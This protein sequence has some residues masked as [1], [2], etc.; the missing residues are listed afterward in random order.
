MVP[1]Y[2]IEQ[3]NYVTRGYLN[4]WLNISLNQVL[5]EIITLY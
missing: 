2:T 1:V 3:D 4:N 5:I